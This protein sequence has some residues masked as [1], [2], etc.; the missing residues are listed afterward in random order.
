MK[1]VVRK[2]VIVSFAALLISGAACHTVDY[3]SAYACDEAADDSSSDEVSTTAET[4]DDV[5]VTSGTTETTD[6]SGG[7]TETTTTETDANTTETSVEPCSVSLEVPL[8]IAFGDP[9]FNNG[10]CFQEY[11]GRVHPFDIKDGHGWVMYPTTEAC[12]VSADSEHP[13]TVSGTPNSLAELFP[14]QAYNPD[15]PSEGCYFISVSGFLG[16]DGGDCL[17]STVQIWNGRGI[18]V[19]L[20]F[21]A[22]TNDASIYFDP[23]QVMLEWKPDT[24]TVR[25]DCSCDSLE[26]NVAC[27]ED[28]GIETYYFGV[29]GFNFWAPPAEV[30]LAML[31]EVTFFGKQAQSAQVCG[32]PKQVS[33]ALW[34]QP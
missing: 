32:S 8:R 26:L 22:V 23:Q 7:S 34:R 12:L 21:A 33:W 17:Y 1:I 31:G 6:G 28:S 14:P 10:T 25:E 5:E 30:P 11:E 4:S 24:E 2:T 18:A 15:L 19:K 29:D 13:L 9:T 16:Q 3:C 20:L 27:C